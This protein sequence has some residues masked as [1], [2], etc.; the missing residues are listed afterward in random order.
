M[1]CNRVSIST[2]I[3]RN[4]ELIDEGE[5]GFI[6][7]G[8]IAS[9]LDETLGERL[10]ENEKIGMPWVRLPANISAKDTPATRSRSLL[11]V[12]SQLFRIPFGSSLAK[13]NNVGYWKKSSSC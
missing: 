11:T 6:A 1:L 13:V 10:G 12:S 3:G 5:T 7:D 4:R 2:D 8:A 9:L